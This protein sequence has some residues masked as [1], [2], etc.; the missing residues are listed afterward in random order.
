[1]DYPMLMNKLEI[2]LITYNRAHDLDCTL[3]QLL[4]SPFAQCKITILDNCSSDE[5]PLVCVEYENLFPNL[6]IIR[7]HK[8]IGG[9]ANYLRAVELSE[10]LYTWVLCD[11]DDLDFSECSDVIEAIESERFDLISLGSPGQFEWERGLTTTSKELIERGARYYHTFS[12]MPGFIFKTELYSSDCIYKGYMVAGDLY[13]QNIFL[14]K[15][16]EQNFSIYMSKKEIIKRGFHNQL[17]SVFSTLYWLKAS[18][19]TCATISDKKLRRRAIYEIFEGGKLKFL[20]HLSFVI[21][22]EKLSEKKPLQGSLYKNYIIVAL[23]LSLDQL[24]LWLLTL[25]ILLTPAPVLKLAVKAYK[26]IRDSVRD[27]KSSLES[28]AVHRS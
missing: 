18:V 13:P 26:F 19:N 7:H 16:V 12:F 20:I 21:I 1:M 15:S 23:G 2:L 17:S 14:N 6:K 10:S 25:P 24:F 3:Q 9:L 4:E 28:K 27:N 22:N 8:N 5:T 11:D